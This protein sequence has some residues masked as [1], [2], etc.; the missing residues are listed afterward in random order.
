[1]TITRRRTLGLASAF[2][3]LGGTDAGLASALRS[4]T[5]RFRNLQTAQCFLLLLIHRDESSQVPHSAPVWIASSDTAWYAVDTMTGATYSGTNNLYKKRGYRLERV[6]AFKTREGVR[7]AAIW[8]LASGPEWHSS[9][10]MSLA[11]FNLTRGK[12]GKDWRMAHVNAHEKFSAIWEKGDGSAQQILVALSASD[13]E[14]QAGQL[15]SQGLRPLR[16]TTSAEGNQPRFTAIFETNNGSDWQAQHQMSAAQFDRA[17]ASMLS[18]GYKLTDASGV[19]LGRKPSF[20]G[21]WEK[22]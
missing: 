21:I 14:A 10:G 1:M 19:M 15:A 20:S 8:E 11:D 4:R 16:I 17:N 7:Y 9:H 22:A 3:V 6:S 18:Q 12:Y 5:L 2:A 13:F